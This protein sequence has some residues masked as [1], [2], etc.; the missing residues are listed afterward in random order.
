MDQPE[1]NSHHAMSYCDSNRTNLTTM[2]L[3][4]NT[5]MDDVNQLIDFSICNR[6]PEDKKNPK[7]KIIY[8][9]D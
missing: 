9:S 4:S 3:W 2:G 1:L 8:P 5:Y 6:N 7:R